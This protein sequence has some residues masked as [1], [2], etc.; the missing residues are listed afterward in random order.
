MSMNHGIPCLC[1]VVGSSIRSV[2]VNCSQEFVISAHQNAED[3]L[4]D[5]MV[6]CLNCRREFAWTVHPVQLCDECV[7]VEL[8]QTDKE[9]RMSNNEEN[10]VNEEQTTTLDMAADDAA[11]EP[12]LPV[13]DV[14]EDGDDDEEEEEDDDEADDDDDEDEGV[15]D[16]VT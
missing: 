13:V 15:D 10:P 3:V 6:E 16:D 8:E 14:E 11:D 5:P 1:V 2:G 12:A 4:S 9:Q 7:S